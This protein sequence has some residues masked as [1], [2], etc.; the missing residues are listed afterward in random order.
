MLYIVSN[1][2]YTI[3]D[4]KMYYVTSEQLNNI[5]DEQWKYFLDLVEIKYGS[6]DKNVF[7]QILGDKFTKTSKKDN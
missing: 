6:E 2:F 1:E 7:N 3:Q 5:S 4:K